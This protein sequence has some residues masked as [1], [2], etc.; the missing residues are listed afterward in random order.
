[1][2]RTMI[3]GAGIGLALIGAITI[4]IVTRDRWLHLL[5]GHG[6]TAAATSAGAPAGDEH[7]GHHHDEHGHGETRHQLHLSE[8]ARK[9]LGLKIG[10]I[11]LTDYWRVLMVPA[12]VIEQ[13][14]RSERSVTTAVTGF[15][16]AV[17]AFPG[18]AVRPGDPLFD[19][20]LTGEALATAQ[21]G[22]LKTLQD[23]ELNDVERRR[24]GPLVQ[25]GS[26]PEKTKL[27]LEYDHQRLESA[28]KVQMQELLV[29]GLTPPQIQAIVST[30]QLLREFTIHAPTDASIHR[31]N[32]P[33]SPMSGRPAEM[34]A[35][36]ATLT[37]PG[38]TGEAAGEPLMYTI[39][40]LNVFPGKLVQPGEQLCHLAVHTVLHIQGQAFER[41]AETIGR[42]AKARLPV[43]A[44]FELGEAKPLVRENLRIL[45]LD[46]V[47]DP[48]NRTFYFYLPLS[49]EVLHDQVGENGIV[50]RSWRFKPG[51][52][53]QLR[54]P[55]EKWE[56]RFVLPAEAVVKEG[57]DA[58]VF[59]ANGD[60]LEQRAVQVEYQDTSTMVVAN[61]GSL[62]PGDAVALNNAYQLNLALKKASGEGGGHSHEGHSHEGHNH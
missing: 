9:N 3:T 44:L 36:S 10:E 1:M 12:T 40:K 41:E 43:T 51:Q 26:V 11:E 24:V 60:M 20:Q 7:A 28:R 21:A 16:Q 2:V 56:E 55:V 61:D 38:K 39:E 62:F 33:A 48:L 45:Y 30:K 6:R 46:N 47:V 49:N 50:Y 59:L 42:A 17:H 27:E 19:L 32:D 5:P 22:L 23:L 25:A 53:T 58:F 57:A 29:R 31:G 37:Q 54:V 13:P 15:I 35:A 4:G 8:Q 52:K 18:Q 14:G 34:T